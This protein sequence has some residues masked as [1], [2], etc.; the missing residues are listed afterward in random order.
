MAD[1]LQALFGSDSETDSETASPQHDLRVASREAEETPGS[2]PDQAADL[3]RVAKEESESEEETASHHSDHDPDKKSFHLLA[4]EA[5]SSADDEA[6]E[7][8]DVK[9][10]PPRVAEDEDEAETTEQPA[11]ES[12]I[13]VPEAEAEDDEETRIEVDIARLEPDLGGRFVYWKMQDFLRVES[14][15]FDMEGYDDE[16]EDYEEDPPLDVQEAIRQ[17]VKATMRWKFTTMPDGSKGPPESNVKFVK[18]SD[19]R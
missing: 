5:E 16:F 7:V 13:E 1:Q 3:P 14:K 10:G 2:S 9:P 8:D 15:P 12:A 4:D 11:V 18:W 19:G 6:H 17:K